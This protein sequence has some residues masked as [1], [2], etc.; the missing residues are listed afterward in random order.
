MA[1]A[2]RSFLGKWKPTARFVVG[3][4]LKVAGGTAAAVDPDNELVYKCLAAGGEQAAEHVFDSL[5]SEQKQRVDDRFVLLEPFINQQIHLVEQVEKLVEQQGGQLLSMHEM[6]ALIRSRLPADLQPGLQQLGAGLHAMQRWL[7]G[8]LQ[9]IND[10]IAELDRKPKSPYHISID[11]PNDV[12]WLRQALAFSRSLPEEKRRQLRL[13]QF[14]GLLQ[15][16]GLYDAASEVCTTAAP[17]APDNTQKAALLLKKV[18]ADLEQQHLDDALNALR[19]AAL[20]D[21]GSAPFP[22]RKYQPVRL[23]GVG[24]F[25]TA[26]LCRDTYEDDKEVVVKC[27]HAEGMERKPQEM[28]R[29]VPALQPVAQGTSPVV[30]QRPLCHLRRRCSPAPSLY[31]HG[32]FRRRHADA[33]A[34]GQ[35]R[36]R[37][38]R[39]EDA[40][41]RVPGHRTANC[42]G[43]PR[44]PPAQDLP[45]RPQAR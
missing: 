32:L 20:L 10:K 40:A 45:P 31:R 19:E 30:R 21:P 29:E 39:P 25:G 15:D 9:S 37:H 8:E 2:F 27:L 23:L 26:V 11:D 42:P 18:R 22:A 3:G 14:A 34:Q 7:A 44:R 4:L 6:E 38:Q 1:W 33:L 28:F 35:L 12:A 5:S 41:G 36:R 13:G 43:A 17:L 24:G 16:A